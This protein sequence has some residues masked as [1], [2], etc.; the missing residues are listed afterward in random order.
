M[1]NSPAPAMGITMSADS[2]S[3][4]ASPARRPFQ[5]LVRKIPFRRG[6]DRPRCDCNLGRRNQ[7]VCSL[8][9][10]GPDNAPGASCT[11]AHK[12][13]QVAASGL[14]R[15]M[16]VGKNS[17]TVGCTGNASRTWR[18]LPLLAMTSPMDWITSSAAMPT[19]ALVTDLV[20]E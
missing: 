3:A 1:P 6:P 17:V 7:Q 10:F 18:Q 4:A 20:T 14:R 15:S 8:P 16:I 9:R 13:R 11:F 12:P 5:I 19:R 2:T